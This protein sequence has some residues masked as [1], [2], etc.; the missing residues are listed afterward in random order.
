MSEG[1]SSVMQPTTPAISP[2]TD[3]SVL[4]VLAAEA[5]ADGHRMVARLIEEWTNGEN[6]FDRPGERS[7]VVTMDGRVC[8]VCGLNV[9]P[10][11]DGDRVGRVRRLY[12]SAAIR[13]RGLG[14]AI[15]Q[16]LTRDA[17]S[18]FRELH[19]RTHDPRASAFYEAIG[20]IPVKDA[21]YCTHRR[22]VPA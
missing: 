16:Q 22:P 3:P 12:V 20:F 15:M 4:T 10:F 14:S 19:L 21:E 18:H 7:Y 8:G 1:S 17:A 6:R 9:D 2:L 11:A 13:R 5:M